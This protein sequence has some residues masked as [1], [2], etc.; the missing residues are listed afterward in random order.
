MRTRSK[1]V[2]AGLGATLLMALGVGTASARSLSISN[3]TFSNTFNNL[4]F[5]AEGFS[6]TTC[7]VTLEGSLHT[8]S[9]AKV[10][11]S[12]IGYIT[13]VTTSECRGLE[14]R[15]LTAT[16]PWHVSY[17]GFSGRLPDITLI[18]IRSQ[19]RFQVGPCLSGRDITGRLSRDLSGH[20]ILAQIPLQRVELTG[21]LC[22]S[23]GSFQ[24]NGNG[25]AFQQGTTTRVSV[26]LI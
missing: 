17:E 6:P 10:L 13:R 7:H 5:I 16:L 24:S 2:L 15:I 22:P 3:Q 14:V 19:S 21:F 4:E 20:L 26:T 9:M 8:R 11:G 12:L 1:L 23:T 18:L 25:S